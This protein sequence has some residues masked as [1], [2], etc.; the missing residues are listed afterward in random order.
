MI[1]ISGLSVDGKPI[2]DTKLKNNFGI[3]ETAD[4]FRRDIG[5]VLVLQFDNETSAQSF[6]KRNIR[7]LRMTLNNNMA[8]GETR[9]GT[10]VATGNK[11]SVIVKNWR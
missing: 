9:R 1:Q 4:V 7:V 6:A 3:V 2:V 10:I 11:V 8:I 5:R